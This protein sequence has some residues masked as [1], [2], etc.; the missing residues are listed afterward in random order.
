MRE[1]DQIRAVTYDCWATLLRDKEPRRSM[2]F[3]IDALK[4]FVQLSTED[5]AALLKEAWG[6]HDEAW[7]QV[8][9]FGPGRMAAYCLETHGIS[10][11]AA[12]E[13]LSRDF[14]EASL[15]GGVELAPE[16][17]AAV[18]TL[19]EAGIRIG[20]VCDTGFSSGR[21]VRAL[22][23]GQ[24]IAEHIEAF[25]FSDEVGVPKPGKEIFAKALAELGA[26]PADSVHVGDLKRTDV[27]GARAAGMHAVRYRGIRDD[28]ADAPEADLVIDRHGQLLDVMGLSG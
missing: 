11:D 26:R 9:T 3:R 24:G 1:F 16:A 23:D 7:K 13:E 4:R 15:K 8:E 22:L 19:R 25:S 14:E 18:T 6:K 10:D 20:L 17:M 5:A 12:L 27:A 21:V 2:N 28:E